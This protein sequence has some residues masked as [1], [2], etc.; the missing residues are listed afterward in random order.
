MLSDLKNVRTRTSV[1]LLFACGSYL[2]M[3]F[4]SDD[5]ERCW[6]FILPPESLLDHGKPRSNLWNEW[7][8]VMFNLV[9]LGVY[10]VSGSHGAPRNCLCMFQGVPFILHT[11]PCLCVWPLLIPWFSKV[12]ES[13]GSQWRVRP[14]RG[15]LLSYL[16]RDLEPQGYHNGEAARQRREWDRPQP[17][18]G[19]LFGYPWIIHFLLSPGFSRPELE[20]KTQ[21]KWSKCPLFS[22]PIINSSGKESASLQSTSNLSVALPFLLDNSLQRESVRGW[23]AGFICYWRPKRERRNLKSFNIP[24]FSLSMPTK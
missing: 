24:P 23:Y 19:K 17:L 20:T 8:N 9:V 3:H 11:C 4:L 2:K 1:F 14:E 18:S 5:V 13:V 22:S 12:G 15:G 7:T 16:L 21:D 6:V 10:Y